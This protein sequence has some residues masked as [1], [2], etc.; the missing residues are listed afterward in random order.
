MKVCKTITTI[1][2]RVFTLTEEE[3]EQA[4]KEWVSKQP[5][6]G[7]DLFQQYPRAE[8]RTDQFGDGAEITITTTHTTEEQLP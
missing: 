3:L 1:S 7:V 8:V 4:V 2:R 5:N 6:C